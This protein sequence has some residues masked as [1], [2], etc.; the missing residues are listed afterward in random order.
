MRLTG[1]EIVST[2]YVGVAGDGTL[3][4]YGNPSR[5]ARRLARSANRLSARRRASVQ[6]LYYVQANV[7]DDALKSNP[8]ILNGR[9]AS[10]QGN[11]YLKAASYLLHE[12]YFSRI[13]S[14]LLNQAASIL[15]DDSGIP[16]R[17]FRDGGWRCWFFGTYSGT[18]DIFAKYYQSDLQAAFAAPGAA[19]A[20]AIWNRL[21]VATWRVQPASGRQTACAK[22]G[23][24]AAFAAMSTCRAVSHSSKSAGPFALAEVRKAL[25]F[26]MPWRLLF[27]KSNPLPRLLADRSRLAACRTYGEGRFCS[28]GFACSGVAHF[29]K[30]L[31]LLREYVFR[32]S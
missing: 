17:F 25:G 4:E 29:D 16:F 26:P 1:G 19:V 8:A 22:P 5:F 13:R 14:F 23:T 30:L 18:L 7:A 12:S 27:V 3:Q 20:L 28:K 2:R 6:T 15:Q 32:D 21:Q 31:T 24:F 9:G 10:A 11:V